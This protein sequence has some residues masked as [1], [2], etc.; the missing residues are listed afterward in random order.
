MVK[1]F[2]HFLLDFTR[3]G[4]RV[5]VIVINSIKGVTTNYIIFG[6]QKIREIKIVKNHQIKITFYFDFT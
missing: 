5:G 6:R 3:A 4:A 2:V 1:I